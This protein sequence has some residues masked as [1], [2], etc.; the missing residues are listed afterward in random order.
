MGDIFNN[1]AFMVFFIQVMAAIGLLVCYGLFSRFSNQ[2]T[3]ERVGDPEF[4]Q[5]QYMREVRLR[6]QGSMANA[7]GYG[8]KW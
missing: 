3:N 2:A 1:G 5:A 6:Y 7:N 4:S 8:R